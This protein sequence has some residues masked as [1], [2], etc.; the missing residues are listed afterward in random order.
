MNL[1]PQTNCLCWSY[2]RADLTTTIQVA[3]SRWIFREVICKQL[4]AASLRHPSSWRSPGSLNLHPRSV[5]VTLKLIY[6]RQ[7]LW[8]ECLSLFIFVE[9]Y[10]TPD[11]NVKH[12]AVPLDQGLCTFYLRPVFIDVIMIHNH[13][14]L[15]EKMWIDRLEESAVVMKASY[16]IKHMG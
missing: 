3:P 12:M 1:K 4:G 15:P 2:G 7:P 16:I 6:I 5:K 14:I 8:D 10:H 9:V 13:L 11:V